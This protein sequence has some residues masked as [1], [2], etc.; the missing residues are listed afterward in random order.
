MMTD[1]P[2]GSHNLTWPGLQRMGA[3]VVLRILQKRLLTETGTI[4]LLVGKPGSGKSFSALWIASKID[5][6]FDASRIV[7]NVR[8]YLRLLNAGTAP[9]Q[10]ILL[11][12]AGVM[13]P[14]R[15]WQSQENVALSLTVESVRHRG[16][17]TLITVP[18]QSMVDVTVRK[19]THLVIDCRAVD[20]ISSEVVARPYLI[21][22]D[23]MTGL[24]WR[25]NPWGIIGQRHRFK[26]S[27]MRLGRPPDALEAAYL[28]KRKAAMQ[29][30]YERLAESLEPASDTPAVRGCAGP[31]CSEPPY[32]PTARYCWNHSWRGT[33]SRASRHN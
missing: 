24:A 27:S 7:F 30:V 13:A 33:R 1:E 9:G 28:S 16:L 23:P 6:S 31:G 21:R 11:D 3:R 17:L 10:A 8:D 4:I 22:V 32:A 5:P 18:D 25:K 12:E 29:A 15:R 2:L 19:L 26:V 20:R 14:S